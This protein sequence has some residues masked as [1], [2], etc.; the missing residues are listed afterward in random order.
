V[1]MYH[2]WELYQFKGWKGQA[3]PLAASF[4]PLHLAGDY[5]QIHYRGIYS[6]PGHHPRAQRVDFARA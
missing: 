1:I 3:E 5:G 2:A 4:N 6:G